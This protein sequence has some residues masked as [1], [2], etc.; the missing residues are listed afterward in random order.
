[1]ADCRMLDTLA[2]QHDAYQSAIAQ[3][4][5]LDQLSDLEYRLMP[6]SDILG[7]SL[8]HPHTYAHLERGI[9]M[10]IALRRMLSNKRIAIGTTH[11]DGV[12][13][14][15]DAQA[16]EISDA[17][18]TSEKSETSETSETDASG[19]CSSLESTAALLSERYGRGNQP[20]L[21]D[22]V[23][24]YKGAGLVGEENIAILQTLGAI[25]RLSFGIESLSGSGKSYTI[26]LLIGLL[27][28]GSVY[29]M[30]LSSRTA[31]L[32][33]AENINTADIIYIPELQKAMNSSNPLVI[34][35][36]KN[37]TEGRDATRKVRHQG[38]EKNKTYTIKGNK[39]VIFTLATEN[40]FKYDAEFSRRVFILHTD[41]SQEQTDSII[42]HKASQR[43][44]HGSY[45]PSSGQQARIQNHLA[46]CLEMSG[47]QYENPF[48][49]YLAAF[50]PRTIRARSY[51]D[52]LFDLMEAS[53]KFSHQQR[54]SQGSVL[55]LSAE[56]V[57]TVHELY[58]KQFVKS[59]LNLPMLGETVLDLLQNEESNASRPFLT[60]EHAYHQIKQQ[61][62]AVSYPVVEE[63]LERMV[64]AGFLL[65][66]DYKARRPC[67][68]LGTGLPVFEHS[69]DW[70]ECFQQGYA[71]M[72]EHHPDTVD[73][74]VSMQRDGNMLVATSPF[75]GRR[76]ELVSSIGRLLG[77]VRVTV[78]KSVPSVEA[79]SA[80]PATTTHHYIENSLTKA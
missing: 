53:A 49:D 43:H 6:Y 10:V 73:D 66:D 72:K 24:H 33:E 5:M 44:A 77:P 70:E 52:Y 46:H 51:D 74:W 67:Y 39:G 42:R 36:L 40:T 12:K 2:G 41:I 65:K 31:E 48:A 69:I 58:W 61:Y 38:K 30:E 37:I 1:M 45:T 32:Y 8:D 9:G 71:F 14:T 34:E 21:H 79:D 4:T 64:T 60:A 22:L 29:R 11:G 55:F 26:D 68:S 15:S 35:V 50:I 23:E 47:T 7:R 13:G 63:T 3:A 27:P 57:Y 16:A 76:A 18:V 28:K 19:Q 78:P 54:L 56:D 25:H 59:L 75:D 80:V 17:S 20:T 62:S